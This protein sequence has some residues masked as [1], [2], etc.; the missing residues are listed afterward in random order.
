MFL[1]DSLYM[2]GLRVAQPVPG[3]GRGHRGWQVAAVG[4]ARPGVGRVVVVGSVPVAVVQ[5]QRRVRLR[6][7]HVLRGGVHVVH[8][9][10]QV[11]VVICADGGGVNGGTGGGLTSTILLLSLSPP[12]HTHTTPRPPIASGRGRRAL[13]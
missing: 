10:L 2:H 3:R 1:P 4:L 6:G 8:Q 13:F 5:E 12:T 9:L 7:V 11:H